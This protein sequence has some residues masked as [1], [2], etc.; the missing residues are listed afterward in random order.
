MWPLVRAGAGASRGLLE[1][2]AWHL[3][4]QAGGEGWAGM[5]PST[6]SVLSQNRPLEGRDRCHSVLCLEPR[7]AHGRWWINI[8]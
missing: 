8:C 6:R 3:L 4:D 1:Q 2:G 5:R 7:L